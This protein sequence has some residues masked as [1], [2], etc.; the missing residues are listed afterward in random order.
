MAPHSLSFRP[1]IIPLNTVVTIKKPKDMRNSAWVSL[2]GSTRFE[3]DEDEE[4]KIEASDS[5][6]SMVVNP[7]DNLTDLWGQRLVNM[8]NWNERKQM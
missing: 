2:D 1:L 6:I 7:S 3:M 4:L 8:F 5:C